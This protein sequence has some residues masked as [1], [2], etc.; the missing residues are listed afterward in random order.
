MKKID[1]VP[2]DIESHYK[3]KSVLPGFNFFMSIVTA[4]AAN[5]SRL[6]INIP[7]SIFVNYNGYLISSD[8]K[9]SQ[10]RVEAATDPD[11]YMNAIR[12][13]VYPEHYDPDVYWNQPA[14]V[15]KK[16]TEQPCYTLS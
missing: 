12:E 5:L 8:I 16:A 6:K 14:S 11:D 2:D 3:G 13:T 9:K 15:L 4:S 10:I 1:L 7:D